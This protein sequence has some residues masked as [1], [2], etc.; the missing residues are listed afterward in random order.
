MTLK[1]LFEEKNIHLVFEISIILK[2]LHALLEVVGGIAIFFI[3]Q[4]FLLQVV[5]AITQDEL[6]GDPNDFFSNYLV[7]VIQNFSTGSQH[8][9]SWYLLSHGV[10]K[11]LL[12][13]G[14]LK[15]K[16]WS[17][18][19]AIV[20]FTL[21]IVYQLVRYTHT[22]SVWLLLLTVLDLVIIA[23]TWHEYQYMMKIKSA[24]QI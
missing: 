16:L 24:P 3:S 18:P 11:G 2:G 4:E 15:E 7:N 1:Q 22:G 8:F 20:V 10:I 23:L 21:F 13:I 19:L 9:A 12:V 17:Y 14:L 6:T 5:T